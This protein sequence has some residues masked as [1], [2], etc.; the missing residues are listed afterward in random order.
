MSSNQIRKLVHGIDI[1]FQELGSISWYDVSNMYYVFDIIRLVI[2]TSRQSH[3]K[4]MKKLH[5]IQIIDLPL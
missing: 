4:D 2:N 1:R 3:M 5:G